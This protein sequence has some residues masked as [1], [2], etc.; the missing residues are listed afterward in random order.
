MT[1]QKKYINFIDM[2]RKTYPDLQKEN[3]WWVGGG[4]GG[5]GWCNILEVCRREG[6][7]NWTNANNL[8]GGVPNLVILG[9]VNILMSSI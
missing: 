5:G 3:C 1:D 4:G 7:Q 6:Y 8:V 2:H 9:E